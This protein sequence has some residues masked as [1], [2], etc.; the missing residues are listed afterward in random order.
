M[1][2]SLALQWGGQCFGVLD[3]KLQ[4]APSSIS[5]PLVLQVCVSCIDF[6]AS[7][8]S[9]SPPAPSATQPAPFLVW[10]IILLPSCLVFWY[11]FP[12]LSL[13]LAWDHFAVSYLA[14]GF[15]VSVYILRLYQ[16]FRCGSWRC[17]LGGAS[18]L[19]FCFCVS[20]DGCMGD[21]ACWF[22]YLSYMSALL[23]FLAFGYLASVYIQY[24][25]RFLRCGF[26]VGV[27]VRIRV[28]IS[29]ML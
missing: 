20:G 4:F 3:L 23:C 17:L 2:F 26:G 24:L 28:A 27:S 25:H 21:V 9:G 18:L 14:L 10:V 16:F 15:A 12:C 11:D 29:S 1:R 19:R 5:P 6:L 22:C 13:F 8:F 7:H